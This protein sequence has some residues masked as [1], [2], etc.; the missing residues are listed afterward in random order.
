MSF[1]GPT[2]TLSEYISKL[3]A[4]VLKQALWMENVRNKKYAMLNS[5]PRLRT[6]LRMN[7]GRNCL[8]SFEAKKG[9]DTLLA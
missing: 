3:E 5:S 6:N 4:F 8:P 9:V 7:F 1:Q 2:G